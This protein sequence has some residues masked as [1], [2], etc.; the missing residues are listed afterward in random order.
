V[1]K[2]KQE[3][4][5]REKQKKK[6]KRKKEKKTY[7]ACARASTSSTEDRWNDATCGDDSVELAVL[8]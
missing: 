4:K 1:R 5:K 7:D 3:K 8:Q 2:K 6:E